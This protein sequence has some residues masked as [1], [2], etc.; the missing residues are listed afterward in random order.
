M[1]S[2]SYVDVLAFSVYIL[3]LLWGVV[4]AAMWVARKRQHRLPYEYVPVVYLPSRP[5]RAARRRKR[6]TGVMCYLPMSV[7]VSAAGKRI[8]RRG[9]SS[10]QAVIHIEPDGVPTESQ[11]N[12]QRLIQHLQ[13]MPT[14]DKIAS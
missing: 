10:E 1:L 3:L 5:R 7:S 8:A 11:R 9:N 12:I 6:A 13:K 14:G 4:G 2:S